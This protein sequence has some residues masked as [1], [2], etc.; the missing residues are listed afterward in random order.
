MDLW[1]KSLGMGMA[2]VIAL[3]LLLDHTKWIN[4]PFPIQTF[5]TIVLVVLI[6]L[7]LKHADEAEAKVRKLEGEI[8]DHLSHLDLPVNLVYDKM[9][10]AHYLYIPVE[11][12]RD[13]ITQA[14]IDGHYEALRETGRRIGPNEAKHLRE[15]Y[16]RDTD[17]RLNYQM[18]KMEEE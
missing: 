10:D 5:L 15:K 12:M 14:L 9:R 1:T 4:L 8:P 7:M 2:V 13:L 11:V 16:Q 18:R 3:V 6:Y 17:E